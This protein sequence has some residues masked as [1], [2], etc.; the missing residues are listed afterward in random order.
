MSEGRAPAGA[1]PQ[2]IFLDH[3]HERHHPVGVNDQGRFAVRDG[4]LDAVSPEDPVAGFLHGREVE[5]ALRLLT[6]YLRGGRP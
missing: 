4:H 5:G 2:Q 6:G 3:L 1:Q